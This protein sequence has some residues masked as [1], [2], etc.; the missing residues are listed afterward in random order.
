MKAVGALP[1]QH[2]ED[3]IRGGFIEG[4]QVQNI[5]PSSIDLTL[6]NEIFRVNGAFLPSSDETV[7]NALKRAGRK[8][9]RHG[10][11]LEPGACYVCRLEE[12]IPRSLP[13][14]VYGY[15]NP[16]SSTGRVDVHVRLLTDRV[17]GYDYV[18]ERYMGD[19]WALI[20]PKTFPIISRAGITLNQ[21]R[22][23]NGD[24]R[25]SR[26]MLEAHFEQDGGFL[27]TREGELIRYHDVYHNDKDGSVI[28][29]I[30]LGFDIPG[31]EAIE[32]GEPIDLSLKNH[33]DPEYFF[34]P[35]TVRHGTIVLNANSFY[36]LSTKEFVRV[37]GS[38]ACEM[39][40]MDERSGEF[41]SHYAGFIDPGWGT[42]TDGE[43][44]GR[45][46]TLE[47]RSSDIRL[48]IRDG[49]RI[50]KVRYERVIEQ[51]Y[52]LYGQGNPNYNRQAGPGLSKHFKTG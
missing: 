5:Q 42:G 18:P 12:R 31:Y 44:R 28:L 27:A 3:L 16:K 37:P 47:V 11:I 10:G 9:I 52:V 45:P 23:F 40:P 34:R 48:N 32:T 35:V 22:L 33:Y 30:G 21:L 24:T 4:G 41:R 17:T 7:E 25:F 8:K 50:A 51:P 13:D 29:T 15:A 43:M 2:I 6:T 49:Q 38:Y 26:F 20:V 39:R 1:M 46:L 19:L 14:D 36:I